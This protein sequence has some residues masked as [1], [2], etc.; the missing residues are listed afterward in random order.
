MNDW[1]E[2]LLGLSETAWGM[3]AARSD[4]RLW[5]MA[6]VDETGRPQQ[7]T[8]VLRDSDSRKRELQFHT[9][10]RS[11]KIQ[12]I[13]KGGQISLLC[14]MPNHQLQLR[15]LASAT[16]KTGEAVANVWDAIPD[17]ARGAYGANPKTGSPIPEALGYSKLAEQ[18]AFAVVD[19]AVTTLEVLHLGDDHR[20]A[21]FSRASDWRG[22]WLVP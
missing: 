16:I 1:F 20:R 3:I 17:A 7:R 4:A 13:A 8:V 22:Q 5:S 15:I 12:E 10:I 18:N 19:C 14:W 21:I 11:S 2:T 9:D 6:T